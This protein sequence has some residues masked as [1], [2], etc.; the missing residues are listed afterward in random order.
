[1]I[2]E[3]YI[4]TDIDKALELKSIPVVTMWNRLE[5]RPR[6]N[7]FDR[8]LKAE[9]RDPLWMLTRQWQMG[10][11]QGDDAGTPIFAKIMTATTQ[12][13]RYKALDNPVENFNNDVP[14]EAEVEQRRILF[15][16]GNSKIQLDLRVQL[17]RHWKKMLVEQGMGAYSADYQS[18]Y[19]FSLPARDSNSAD[20]YAFREVWQ[21]L[22]ALSGRAMDGGDLLLYLKKKNTNLASDGIVLADPA[23]KAILDALG[24]SFTEWFETIYYQ[25][26]DEDS[27][28]WNP[29][30]LEYGFTCSAPVKGKQKI[31]QAEEY[32]HG[33]LDWYS[34]DYSQ[35]ATQLPAPPH[36]EPAVEETMVKSFIPSAVEFEGMPNRRWWKFEDGK[37]YL[38]D[39]KPSTTDLAKLLLME[40]ALIYSND[41]FIVPFKL[42]TGTLA[43]IKGM[44]VTNSFGER[45]WIQASGQGADD[46]WHSWTMFTINK[47]GIQSYQKADTTLLLTP[48]VPK[49]Q[50]GPPLEEVTF[51]RDEVANMVWAVETKV[52]LLTGAAKRGNES[53]FLV[54]S[55]HENLL[56]NSGTKTIPDYVAPISYLAMTTVPENWIP[57]LA[58]HE[59]N[60]NR[61]IVLQRASMLRIMEGDPN[62]PHRVAPLTPIVREGLD[63]DT[64]QGYFIHEEE[65]PRAGAIVTRSFQRTRWKDGKIFLWSGMR[66]TT[67]RGEG[68]SG[69][70][71]DQIPQGKKE[72]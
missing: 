42:P 57:F 33:H 2:P 69:L 28:A 60:S 41:W 58:A 63:E 46:D 4:I 17:G 18:K 11:F 71:F 39:V 21:Q 16:R 50:E 40:F 3:Q 32:Y 31:L 37:T 43:S 48:S 51:L 54:R 44:A 30:A 10:E 27:D 61:D 38:G 24:K 56:D 68:S 5:G 12:L 47:K 62:P 7:N 8:A 70:A 45:T 22:A 52:P 20:I 65:V 67:G 14:L 9:V 49:I 72:E 13:T 23:H 64:P 66:K 34:F 15:T 36:P 59:Q 19:H 35:R 26:K 25:P 53:A 29:P 1:M 6:T 55:Y